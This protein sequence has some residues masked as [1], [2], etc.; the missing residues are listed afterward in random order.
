MNTAFC[1]RVSVLRLWHGTCITTLIHWMRPRCETPLGS[2]L[3]STTSQAL[4]QSI[5]SGAN[6]MTKKTTS[7]P[8]APQSGD[9]K[10][11]YLSIA[12]VE[13]GSYITWCEIWLEPFYWWEKEA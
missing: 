10:E 3:E 7:G 2:C 8:F 5:R 9:A 12:L 4:R 1:E 13:T 6:R 11:T